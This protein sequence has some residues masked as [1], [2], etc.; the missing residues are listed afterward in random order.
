MSE[1]TGISAR[2]FDKSF[3]LLDGNLMIRVSSFFMLS[4][5]FQLAA[6]PEASLIMKEHLYSL[7]QILYEISSLLLPIFLM[8]FLATIV[9]VSSSL[10]FIS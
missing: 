1:Y 8:S 5:F 10:N 6:R 4:R 7:G 3:N 2:L 9:L